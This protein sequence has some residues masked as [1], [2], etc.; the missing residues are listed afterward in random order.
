MTEE[1]LGWSGATI[2]DVEVVSGLGFDFSLIL[3]NLGSLMTALSDRSAFE[4]IAG[5][6]AAPSTVGSFELGAGDGREA[7][8]VP[9]P[10]CGGPSWGERAQLPELTFGGD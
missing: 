9:A 2:G 10:D 4:L 3:R 8:G 1:E 7:T 5:S 6:S